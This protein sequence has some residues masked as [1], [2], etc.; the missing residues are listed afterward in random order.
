M[1]FVTCDEKNSITFINVTV[2]SSSW[3]LYDSGLIM[4][5]SDLSTTEILLRSYSDRSLAVDV[6]NST[7]GELTAYRAQIVIQGRNIQGKIRESMT[8]IDIKDSSLNIKSSDF[9]RNKASHGPAIIKAVNSNVTITENVVFEDNSGSDRLI[10]IFHSALLLDKCVFNN[11]L[12]Y[13][14]FK[15]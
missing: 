4:D 7:F 1:K 2:L 8:L 6:S 9:H 3:T 13:P 15:A 12:V 5:R 10:E 14:Y 11:N